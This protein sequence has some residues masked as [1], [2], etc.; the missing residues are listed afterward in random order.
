[1]CV[2]G[3][4]LVCFLLAFSLIYCSLLLGFW[5]TDWWFVVFLLLL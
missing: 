4:C 5:F 3:C 2:V 1:M